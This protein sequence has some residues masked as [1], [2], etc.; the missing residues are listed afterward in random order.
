MPARQQ[1]IIWTNDGLIY[2]RSYAALGFN[3][4]KFVELKS[5]ILQGWFADS[6]GIHKTAPSSVLSP[7]KIYIELYDNK[8]H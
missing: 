1:A 8:T 5:P 6:E 7:W 3:E 2:W 4:S